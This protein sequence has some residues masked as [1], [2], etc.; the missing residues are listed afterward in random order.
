MPRGECGLDLIAAASVFRD[1]A[2]QRATRL[3]TY[4]FLAV[5]IASISVI[6]ALA[7]TRGISAV[8]FAALASAI[9]TLGGCAIASFLLGIFNQSLNEITR[10]TPALDAHLLIRKTTQVMRRPYAITGGS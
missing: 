5:L 9:F 2:F 4:L 1:R 8:E 7:R 3:F 6:A 10:W